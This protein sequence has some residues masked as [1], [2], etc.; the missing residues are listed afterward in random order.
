MVSIAYL[1]PLFLAHAAAGVSKPIPNV[2]NSFCDDS[3]DFIM[4]STGTPVGSNFS[5]RLCMSVPGASSRLECTK[6]IPCPDGP[7]LAVSVFTGGILYSVSHN[8]T[9]VAKSCPSCAPP[10]GMPFSFLLI[11]GADGDTSRGVAKYQGQTSIDGEMMDHFSHDRGQ[12]AKGL[13]VMNWYLVGNDLL[14]TAYVPPSGNVGARDFS[15]RLSKGGK[16][17][18]P[19]PSSS[20]DVPK[21]CKHQTLGEFAPRKD[22]FGDHY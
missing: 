18:S 8:G 16:R 15:G 7:E 11:D 20:F 14:R 5:Y 13:G 9:C 10:N 3:V 1:L 19:A 4:S 12:V 22:N 17:V 21:E 2:T 6:G